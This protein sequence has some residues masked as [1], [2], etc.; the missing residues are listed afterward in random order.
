MNGGFGSAP[1][2]R[3]FGNNKKSEAID[4]TITETIDR[5]GQEDLKFQN[6]W[7]GVT[8]IVESYRNQHRHNNQ[9]NEDERQRFQHSVRRKAVSEFTF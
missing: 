2:T 7:V 4:E 1:S 6:F 5:L 3:G 8:N 9:A